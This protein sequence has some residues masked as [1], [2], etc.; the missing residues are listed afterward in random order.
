MRH[1]PAGHSYIGCYGCSTPAPSTAASP[2]PGTTLRASGEPPGAPAFPGFNYRMTCRL[3]SFWRASR[4]SCS[5]VAIVG[6]GG[7][8]SNKSSCGQSFL[9]IFTA[10]FS[11]TMDRRAHCSSLRTPVPH[12]RHGVPQRSPRHSDGGFLLSFL[13]FRQ[14][15]RP[16][17]LWSA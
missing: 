1:L 12:T 16:S 14:S 11:R 3:C 7:R 9:L 10:S 8:Q 4:G 15:P 5:S 2:P 13:W 6:A 17:A